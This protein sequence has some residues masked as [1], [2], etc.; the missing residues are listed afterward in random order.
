[1]ATVL[2]QTQNDPRLSELALTEALK[3]IDSGNV[4]GVVIGGLHLGESRSE[5]LAL[6][7]DCT[8]KLPHHLPRVLFGVGGPLE[9]LDAIARGIDIVG[10]AHPSLLTQ[11]GQAAV[12]PVAQKEQGGGDEG[13][14]TGQEEEE[15]W[16][17][18][19][20]DRRYAR[21]SRPLGTTG[22]SLAYVHH[23][24]QAHEMLAQVLLYWHNLAH[25]LRFFAAVRDAIRAGSFHTYKTWFENSAA[26]E[27]DELKEEEL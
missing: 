9:A 21:D 3:R 22:H 23:L 6:L 8:S 13:R 5:R 16:V 24:L 2:A 7:T 14:E 1:M 11:F 25:Y 15:E 4:A 17:I 19:L 18:N 27:N 12:Y 26:I 20:W 10:S